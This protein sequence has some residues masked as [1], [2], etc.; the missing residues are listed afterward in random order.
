MN[1]NVDEI[2]KNADGQIY[3]ID[4]ELVEIGSTKLYLSKNNLIAVMYQNTCLTAKSIIKFNSLSDMDDW[5]SKAIDQLKREFENKL[6]KMTYNHRLHP[7]TILVAKTEAGV[8]F[9]QVMSTQAKKL[10]HIKKLRSTTNDARTQCVP[11]VGHFES[12]MPETKRVLSDTSVKIRDEVVAEL[13]ECSIL[14]ITGS[15]VYTPVEI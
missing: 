8:E 2:V 12:M 6:K 15:K 14:E 11:M 1:T 5:S 3:Y 4:S 13:L 9:Y 10:V 7:G